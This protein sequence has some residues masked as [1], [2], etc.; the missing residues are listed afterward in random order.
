M[1]TDHDAAPGP[2]EGIRVVDFSR[3]F[4]GPLCTMQLADFGAD[5][6]KVESPGGDDARHFG[7]PFL[8]GEG[9]N[10]MA[11][12]RGK[13]SVVLDMKSDH[14]REAA[15]RLIAD[16]DVV[17]ENFRPGVAER[18]GIGWEQLRAG[19]DRLVYC[20]ISGFGPAHE[21]GRR[22]AL[23][24]ILQAATGVMTRQAT[25]DGHPQL[26]CVT[27]ADTYAAA[28]GVQGILAALLV[29]ER[30]GQAQRVDVS[31]LEAILT[32][33][34]YRI[35]CDPQTM[36][37]PAFD[38]TV[39]YGAFQGGDGRWLAIAVVSAANWSGLCEV[40][41]LPE[42]IDDPRFATNPARVEH[43]ETLLGLLQA[44]IAERPAAA[45]VQA[46]EAAGVPC[47]PVQDLP[48]LMADPLLLETGVLTEIEHPVAGRVRTLGTPV[49]LSGTPSRVGRAAPL[50]GQHTDEVLAEIG[51][52]GSV[53]YLAGD[54]SS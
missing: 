24:L 27:I 32:A 10:F 37:L 35:V 13:R 31:L 22:P 21:L 44:R 15:Q 41:I 2:L 49:R 23:D 4:A 54:T 36:E 12:N 29:R 5:V 34:A 18:L 11:L 52:T 25:P 28:Q 17:V 16:A 8:G 6:I 19:N 9:M 51:M 33:Q 43:R 39:P 48:D 53:E 20:S 46:L 38:D 14:G 3:L 47:G 40:L 45:W 30:T 1:T 50:L 26:L 42:L 7:P